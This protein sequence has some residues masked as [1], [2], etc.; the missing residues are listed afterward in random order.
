M[1]TAAGSRYEQQQRQQYIVPRHIAYLVYIGTAPLVEEGLEGRERNHLLL[2]CL[3]KRDRGEASSKLPC[4]SR[5]YSNWHL[6]GK[7][8]NQIVDVA[9]I[10]RE[11]L[12]FGHVLVL[13]LLKSDHTDKNPS[14]ACLKCLRNDGLMHCVPERA[15]HP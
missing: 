15:G 8:V 7:K 3:Q 9:F 11:P 14:A 12:T 1:R 13:L 10:T 4:T 6:N 5:R 2:V